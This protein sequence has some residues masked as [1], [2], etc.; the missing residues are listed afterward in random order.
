MAQDL[1]DKIK[2]SLNGIGLISPTFDIHYENEDNIFGFV[3]DESFV[4][5]DDDESQKLI[6]NALKRNLG[7]EEL[8]KIL[9]IFHETPQERVERLAPYRIKNLNHSNFWLHE[10]P[11]FTKY[12]LFI[13]V[14]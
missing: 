10:T 5:K 2:N 14:G 13:D 4:N 11:D 8:I 9:A 6:W 3:S 7:A 12:W 1:I